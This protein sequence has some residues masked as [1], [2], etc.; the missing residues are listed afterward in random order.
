MNTLSTDELKRLV[1]ERGGPLVSISMPTQHAGVE[2]R[3]NPI[4]F[5]KLVREAEDRLIATGLRAS[6]AVQLM[7]P[8]RRLLEIVFWQHQADGLAVFI[9]PKLF[10]HYQLPAH[11]RN[12]SLLGKDS[13]SSPSCRF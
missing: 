11:R 13:I 8:A 5:K 12:L 9:S 2:T 10:R 3:Q 7:E 4:R 1:E 6:V